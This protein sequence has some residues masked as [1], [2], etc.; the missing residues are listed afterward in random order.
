MNRIYKS[1]AAFVVAIVVLSRFPYPTAE[2]AV[3]YDNSGGLGWDDTSGTF[4]FTMGSVSDGILLVWTS[5]DA[6]GD[7]DGVTYNGVA[8][9]DSGIGFANNYSST[10]WYMLSPPSGAHNVVVNTTT[11]DDDCG[12]IAISFSGVNQSDPFGASNGAN[13]SSTTPSVTVNSVAADSMVVDFV[14]FTGA[15]DRTFTAGASQTK[16]QDL[17]CGSGAGDY[18]CATS[19]EGPVS[20]GNITMSY[21]VS[22]LSASWDI[23]AAELNVAGAAAPTPAARDESYGMSVLMF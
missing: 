3:A 22:G 4:A 1:V 12:A 9:T 8:M 6:A 11:V 18:D 20:A 19:H 5:C 7:A 21:T 13:G 14:N 17:A 23:V 15:G 10:L 16:R 2:A